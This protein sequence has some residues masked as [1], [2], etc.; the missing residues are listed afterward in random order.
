MSASAGPSGAEPVAAAPPIRP[1]V[2][3]VIRTFPKLSET[4][5]LREVL[6]LH[7]AGV[8]LE[9]WSLVPPSA[10]E[11]AHMPTAGPLAGL[12]RTPQPA[13]AG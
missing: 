10:D 4:F 9:I 8:P 5:V 3:Y 11:A 2:A 12:I 6:A 7:E 1:A 13:K